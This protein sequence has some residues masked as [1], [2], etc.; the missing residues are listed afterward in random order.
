MRSVSH[1][2]RIT[3]VERSKIPTGGSGPTLLYCG[4]PVEHEE[5]ADSVSFLSVSHL[6]H[7]TIVERSKIPT[8]GSGPSLLYSG[9]INWERVEGVVSSLFSLF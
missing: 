7:I 2:T 3:I 5:R 9:C 6:T 1:L 4:W 8:G